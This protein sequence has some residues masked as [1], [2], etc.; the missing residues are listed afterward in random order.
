[1]RPQERHGTWNLGAGMK[2]SL[3]Q[4]EGPGPWLRTGTG[5]DV[6]GLAVLLL[7]Q[8]SPC[9]NPATARLRRSTAR[10][11][12]LAFE[13]P[14]PGDKAPSA[15]NGQSMQLSMIGKRAAEFVMI[16]GGLLVPREPS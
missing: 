7:P 11:G 5:D 12:A 4:G 16:E 2:P 10:R 1:M 8:P 13:E 3:C 14:A 9:L 6:A 15:D